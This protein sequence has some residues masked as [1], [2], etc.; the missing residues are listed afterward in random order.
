MSSPIIW[1][2]LTAKSLQSILDINGNC[3]ILSGTVNPSSVATSAPIGSIYLNSSSGLSYRKT[4]AGSSTN[5]VQIFDSASGANASLS[6]LTTT[7]I[8]QTLKPAVDGVGGLGT[9]AANWATLGVYS[10]NA[11]NG[12]KAIDLFTTNGR[13]LVVGATRYLSWGIVSSTGIKLDQAT[14]NGFLKTSAGDG[15]MIVDTTSY[16]S[17]TVAIAN[18]GTG[19]TTKAPA[20]DALSPMTTGG[21]IIYG[22]A[23]GTGTRLANGS[24]GQVLTSNGTTAAPSWTNATAP[25]SE[26]WLGAGL[27][28]GSVGTKI[29]TFQSVLRSTGTDITYAADTTNGDT[30]TI[31]TDGV[32]SIYY[33]D[34]NGG[35]LNNI[36]ITVNQPSN[37]TAP[38]TTPAANTLDI[39]TGFALA[40]SPKIS[41]VGFLAATSVIRANTNGA[42][43]GTQAD[44]TVSFHVTRIS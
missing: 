34:Y 33:S 28:T 39:Q 2:G 3:Q 27:G 7:N 23:S 12:T 16:L 43:S 13:G 20:F 10:I 4:D 9:S 17:G 6:N 41:Y 25:R 36:A 11:T 38:F 15:T 14:T 31:N 8:N 32:Y 37:T 40:S 35:G 1:A 44:L 22:G 19:Q 24:A 5:W 26:S 18:G 29:R 30:W 21:D 42:A